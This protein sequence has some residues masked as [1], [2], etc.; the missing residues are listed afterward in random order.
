LLHRIQQLLSSREFLE[1][2]YFVEALTLPGET[3]DARA[4]ENYL[5]NRKRHGRSRILASTHWAEFKTRLGI[6][7]VALVTG[8]RIW[9]MSLEQFQEM[10]RRLLQASGVRQEV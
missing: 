6:S 2:T 4:R 8:H 3:E 9:P 5:S 7:R 10:E 1:A